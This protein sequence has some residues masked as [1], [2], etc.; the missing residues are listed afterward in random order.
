MRLLCLVLLTACSPASYRVPPP[1]PALGPSGQSYC[2]AVEV[3]CDVDARAGVAPDDVVMAD[4]ARFSYLQAHVDNPQG[5]YL[6]T[7][8]GA[9]TSAERAHILVEAQEE[10][11]LDRCAF[12]ESERARV[13]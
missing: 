7:I 2:E 4:Q 9:S 5:V 12:A 1:P 8:L 6:R 10:A 3:I 13:D 11:G